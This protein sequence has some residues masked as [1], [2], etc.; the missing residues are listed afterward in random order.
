M[1]VY[2]S[3]TKQA[4]GKIIFTYSH[5]FGLLRYGDKCTEHL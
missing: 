1:L 3:N 2:L 5:T 4:S